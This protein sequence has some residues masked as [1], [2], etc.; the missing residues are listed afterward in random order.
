MSW[1]YFDGGG[2]DYDFSQSSL[3]DMGGQSF[4]FGFG[5]DDDWLPGF[6]YEIGDFARDG[7]NSISETLD[8]FAT[9]FAAPAFGLGMSAYAINE[10]MSGK[11]SVRAGGFLPFAFP[12]GNG[13]GLG[14]IG[15]FV[16]GRRFDIGG[17][18]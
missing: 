18:R 16:W 13:L 2:G 9:A 1:N 17:G 15:G 6:E 10:L 12:T 11:Q 7:N 8:D 14:G 4:S 3:D 5:G